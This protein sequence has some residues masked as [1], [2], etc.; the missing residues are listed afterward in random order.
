MRPFS[1][2]IAAVVA[3]SR[4]PAIGRSS[5]QREHQRLIERERDLNAVSRFTRLARGLWRALL[6]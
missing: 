6:A 3:G 1:P 5:E 2:G 4:F